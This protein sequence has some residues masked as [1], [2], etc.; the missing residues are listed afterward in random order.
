M[1]KVRFTADYD[2][3]PSTMMTIAYKAGDE[4]IVRRE[5]AERA[6][7]AGKAEWVGA[8]PKGDEAD[9]EGADA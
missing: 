9:T 8:P 4:K 1:A 2:Y 5:A 6:V 7:A 3:K